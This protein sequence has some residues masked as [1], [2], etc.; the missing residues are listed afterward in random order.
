MRLFWKIYL[1]SACFVLLTA[2]ILSTVVSQGQATH[3]VKE[4][5]AQ[6]HLL[7]T[8]A[9]SQISAGYN[10]DHWPF[11]LLGAIRHDK[12]V[13][14][15]QIV[16]GTGRVLLAHPSETTLAA[17][18]SVEARRPIREPELVLLPDGAS[19]CYVVP[20]GMQTESRAWTFR[21]VY[22]TGHVQQQISELQWTN[23]MLAL[24]VTLALVPFSLIMTRGVLRPLGSL[25]RAAGEIQIGNLTP[26]FP[27]VTN[28]EIGELVLAF[29][30]M[31][32]NIQGKNTRITEQLN[33]IRDVRDDLEERV[34][35][36]TAD[37]VARKHELESEIGERQR[38]EHALRE[39]EQW[40]RALIDLAPEAIVVLDPESTRFIEVNDNAIQLFGLD[41]DELRKLG[42]VDLS[43][44]KQPDGRSS[45]QATQEF[46]ARGLAGETPVFEWLYC[47]AEGKE[48]PCE[49]RIVSLPRDGK[50]LIRASITDITQRKLAEAEMRDLNARLVEAARYAGKAEVATSVLH[51]VGNILNSLNISGSMLREGLQRS[52]VHNLNRALAILEE[53]EH[54]LASFLSDDERGRVLPH[55]LKEVGA[56]LEKGHCDQSETVNSLMS[57]IEH[58]K[59][60]VSMQQSLA[61]VGCAIERVDL[62]C[63][64]DEALQIE[65]GALQRNNIRVTKV[66]ASIPTLDIDRHR[67]LQVLIN[68]IANAK[69]SIIE[70]RQTNG[71]IIIRTVLAKGNR[72]RVEVIDNGL[73]IADENTTKIFTFGFTT[74]VEGH[75]FGLHGCANT[76]GEMG[77]TLGLHSQG[78]GHGATFTLELPL[79]P[80]NNL[81][82]EPSRDATSQT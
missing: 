11:E 75:G 48:I 34:G 62:A 21:L 49:I 1:V 27:T 8:I 40:L 61:R 31:A 14:A 32:A 80:A 37:L 18:T 6:Q 22:D 72:F 76:A 60:I 4:L 77:G 30:E 47:N 15:W 43:P 10:E 67:V 63:L 25:T 45:H 42:P 13:T 39:A 9:A 20:L 12:S 24:A 69:D 19:E 44:A 23:A 36:R 73:G 71:E 66:F 38:A 7:A 78:L 16:D 81:D 74:K 35:Q 50:Q 17:A 56:K 29:Q 2:L 54:D 65:A 5:R 82:V 64:I 52:P 70:H 51:N 26:S 41:Q 68:L 57:N 33:V 55:Y 79:Q 3:A 59:S 46:F 28:D 58:I 53:H